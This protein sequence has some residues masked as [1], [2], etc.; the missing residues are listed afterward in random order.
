MKTRTIVGVTAIPLFLLLIFFAPLWGY[1]IVVGLICGGC[2]R[3]F[4]RCVDPEMPVRFK[5]YAFAVAFALPVLYVFF[6]SQYVPAGLLFLLA[7]L[8]I[9]ELLTSFKDDVARVKVETILQVLFAGSVMPMLLL[10]LVRI[11]VSNPEHRAVY[12]LLP[13]LAAAACDTGAYFVGSFRGKTKIFPHLSPNKSWEGCVG[14][15]LIAIGMMLLYAF[16]LTRFKLELSYLAFAVYGLV[17]AV[18]CEFGDL[19]FSA[20]KRQYGVKDYGTLIPGHGGM[21]DRFDSMHFT[22]PMIE[23]LVL[24]LPAIK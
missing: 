16:V 21:L 20:I 17:G 13:L 12:V 5:V 14:G 9:F 7:V 18:A 3:E 23:L 19:A 24:L 15:V 22:A 11:G 4:L 8:M 2:S 1:A 10:S 6:P